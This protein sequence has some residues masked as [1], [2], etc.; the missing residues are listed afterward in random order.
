M[1][2]IGCLLL[3][4]LTCACSPTSQT[5]DPL[6]STKD[7]GNPMTPLA[8]QPILLT[9]PAPSSAVRHAMGLEGTL[10]LEGRC[11]FLRTPSFRFLLAFPDGSL[12][13][14]RTQEIRMGSQ[15]LRVGS[16][17]RL[18]GDSQQSAGSVAP[19]FDPQGCDAARI[20]RVAPWLVR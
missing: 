19:G 4:G 7:S 2:R 16:R 20:F 5:G 11:F 1:S 17:V 3:L 12:W 15:S 18:S 6:P 8:D 9:Y 14:P 10:V 13:I